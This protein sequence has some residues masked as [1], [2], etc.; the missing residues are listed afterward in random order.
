VT[1]TDGPTA[2]GPFRTMDVKGF[3]V[4]SMVEDTLHLDATRDHGGVTTGEVSLAFPGVH[5]TL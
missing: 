5:E 4:Y 2:D 1:D 3:W